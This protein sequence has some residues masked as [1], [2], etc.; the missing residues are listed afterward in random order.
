MTSTDYGTQQLGSV[1]LT[2]E[3]ETADYIEFG[4][5][6]GTFNGSTSYLNNGILRV[7][8]TWRYLQGDPS[9]NALL[10]TTDMVG[11]DVGEL[12]IG[13][14]DSLGSDLQTRSLSGIGTKTNQFSVSVNKR[15]RIRRLI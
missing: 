2:G 7:A 6:S 15:M 10:A 8:G 12:G 9:I 11:S 1:Y 14:S 13:S 5:G 3:F 4:T